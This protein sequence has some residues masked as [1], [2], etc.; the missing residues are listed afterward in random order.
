MPREGVVATIRVSGGRGRGGGM[1]AEVELD[2]GEGGG[3]MVGCVG[4]G[5]RENVRMLEIEHS[6]SKY[7][8]TDVE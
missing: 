2:E 3:G 1:E 7:G 8:T 4:V 5:G 6:F